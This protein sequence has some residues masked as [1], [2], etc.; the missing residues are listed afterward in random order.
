M[1]WTASSA[2]WGLSWQGCP[3]FLCWSSLFCSIFKVH[4]SSS[5]C[6]D[7]EIRTAMLI[8]FFV[9]AFSLTLD[10]I[11]AVHSASLCSKLE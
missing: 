5:L 9:I 10:A 1:S 2:D 6:K 3:V 8:S 7:L 11:G 4:P